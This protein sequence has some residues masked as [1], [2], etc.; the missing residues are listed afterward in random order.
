MIMEERGSHLFRLH[1]HSLDRSISIVG[2]SIGQPRL[3]NS[4]QVLIRC[5]KSK[6]KR[7]VYVKSSPI[8]VYP[9]SSLY[10]V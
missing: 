6:V 5:C 1:I 8:L 9:Y 7:G 2:Y 4:L 3:H 10:Q